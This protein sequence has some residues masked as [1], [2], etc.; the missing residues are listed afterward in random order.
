[1]APADDATGHFQKGFVDD[2]EALEA[3]TQSLEVMQPG[4]R[5]FDDPAGLAKTPA[6]RLAA[7]GD[8][9]SNASGVQR[10]A[11]LVVVVT[12]ITLD[13]AGL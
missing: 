10:L 12:A 4:D 13:D 8:L 2:G 9:C 6:V 11:V 1:M 5:S 3:D 7:T